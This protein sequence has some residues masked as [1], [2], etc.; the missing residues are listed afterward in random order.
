MF[1]FTAKIRKGRIA[2]VAAAAPVVCGG[3][4]GAAPLAGG[5][6]AAGETPRPQPPRPGL[7]GLAQPLCLPPQMGGQQSRRL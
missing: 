1:I 5:R 4:L 7:M 6:G 2:A 3:L